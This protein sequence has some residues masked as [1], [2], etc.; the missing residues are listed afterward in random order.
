LGVYQELADMACERITSAIT[1]SALSEK[2]KPVKALLD[3]YNPTGSSSHVNFTTSKAA[4]WQTDSRKCP[5]NWV[6]LDSDWEAEF[7]RI[8]EG[9]PRLIAYVKN[10]GLGLEIPYRYGSV[11]RKYIPD[12]ITLIDDG[13]AGPLHLIVEIKG[14]R[15]FKEAA[16]A[17]SKEFTD[18]NGLYGR[19][20]PKVRRVRRHPRRRRLISFGYLRQTPNH[21]KLL[22]LRRQPHG[23]IRPLGFSGTARPLHHAP[24]ICGLYAESG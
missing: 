8:A 16:I 20:G 21:A 22:A 3:P 2:Q 10:Q 15:P 24:G 19:F 5:I 4:R 17:A 7:R 6:V 14:I 11:N 12:F 9:E 23:Q 13:S 1:Q 18:R